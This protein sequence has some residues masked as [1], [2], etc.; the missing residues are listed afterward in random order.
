MSRPKP[1]KP[2]YRKKAGTAILIILD[3][4]GDQV[5]SDNLKDG[6]TFLSSAGTAGIWTI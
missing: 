3:V 4:T 2:I 6:G 1:T 5:Y